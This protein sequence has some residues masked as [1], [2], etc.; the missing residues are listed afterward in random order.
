VKV[1]FTL[2]AKVQFLSALNY[3]RQD[4]PP[5]ALRFRK[6]AES[7]LRRLEKFPES[8]RLVPEFPDLPYRELVVAPYRFFYRVEGKIV[9]VVAVWHGAQLPDEPSGK[10]GV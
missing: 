2:S 4:N 1:Q 9:W 7:V 6:R 10:K 5:A 8:G 3:I